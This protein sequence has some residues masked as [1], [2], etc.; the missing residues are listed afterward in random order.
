M[1]MGEKG[2]KEGKIGGK[3]ETA[4]ITNFPKAENIGIKES[5][6]SKEKEKKYSSELLPKLIVSVFTPVIHDEV[7]L[8][9]TCS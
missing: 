2:R 8:T 7:P 9:T 6:T 3:R 5:K 4:I 1:K